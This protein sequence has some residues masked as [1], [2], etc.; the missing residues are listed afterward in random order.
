LMFLSSRMSH[1]THVGRHF[2]SQS[3]TFSGQ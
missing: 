1:Y 3:M 2:P